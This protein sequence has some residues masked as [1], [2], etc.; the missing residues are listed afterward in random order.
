MQYTA[1]LQH[2]RCALASKTMLAVLT[3]AVA[4]T[5]ATQ[6]ASAQTYTVLYNFTGQTD[7]ANPLAGL[8][9]DRGGNLY[10]TASYGG[11]AIC[12]AYGYVGC[13]TVFK[14][15][16]AGGGWTFATLHEFT[17]NPDGAHPSARVVFGPNGAL[18]GTTS[19]GGTQGYGTVFQ[20]QPPAQICPTVSC[21]WAETQLYS[22][23]TL[24][25]PAG[26]SAGD[27]IFDPQGNLYGTTTGGGGFL[28]DD[29]P[30]GTAYELSRTGAGWFLATAWGFGGGISCCPVAGLVSDGSGNFY[31]V[32]PADYYGGIYKLSENSYPLP[33]YNFTQASSAMG[34]MILDSAGDLYGT[35]SQGGS[36]GGG[37]VF[38]FDI[39]SPTPTTLYSFPGPNQFG[40]GPTATL[41]M[42]AAGNLYGITQI[43]GA[44]QQGSV[45]KLSQSNGV[46]SLTT[47][48]DFTGGTDG[49]Q[50]FGQLVMDANGNIYGT[51]QAGGNSVGNCYHGLG[52]GVVFEI[53]PN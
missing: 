8:T 25:G 16:R 27:L 1:D 38:K 24:Y 2:S 44:Y 32:T 9:L 42:D 53:M 51:A 12:S 35:T 46:W 50:P 18:F 17:S 34:G 31:G 20:L 43:D 49:G 19:G 29:G 4:L 39:G 22:F 41:L 40:A 48:H 21:P 3:F 36:G 30:C 11:S 14:L 47:L 23:Q 28:C 10:G 13:G 37:T 33:L 7:G 5:F 45:F 6:P 52:C 26:A 15:S